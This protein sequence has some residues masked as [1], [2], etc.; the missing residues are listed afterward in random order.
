M[1]F[2]LR[3]LALLACGVLSAQAE[4]ALDF[5]RDIRPLL[6][7]RCFAC[8]GFDGRARKGD[9][10]LD[11]PEGAYAP[12][13]HGVTIVPGKPDQSLLWQRITTTDREDVMP[14]ADSHLKLADAEK[15]LLRRWIES[16]AGYEPPWALQ[17]VV[18]PEPP[19]A[20]VHP[21]DAFVGDRLTKEKLAFAPEAPK[22]VLIRR[23]SFDLRARP[24][25]PEEVRDLLTDSAPEAYEKLVD[26]FLADPA[27]GERMAWPWLDAARYADRMVSRAM[28]TGR[29]G[30]GGTGCCSAFNRNLPYDQ[31]TIWQ[32]AGDLLP[33][34]TDEVWR[35]ASCAIIRSTARAAVSR[36]STASIHDGHGGDDGDGVDGADDE[37]RRCHDHKYDPLTQRDYYSLYAFFNQ[38]PVDGSGGN[39]QTPPV[40]AVATEEQRGREE[41]LVRGIDEMRQRVVARMAEIVPAGSDWE[42][43]RLAQDEWHILNAGGITGTEAK[44]LNDGS[45]LTFGDNPVNATYGVR[46]PVPAG[47]LTAVRLD[48]LRDRSMTSGGIARSDSGNFVLTGFEAVL[49]L[50]DGS[51]RKLDFAHAKATYEQGGLSVEGAIDANPNTGW[52]V[53]EGRPVDRDHC[54]VFYLRAA[55][56]VPAGTFV[57]FTLRHES[58][59][60]HHNLGRF[61]L[62]VSGTEVPHLPAAEAMVLTGIL[63]IP[64]DLRTPEQRQVV[65]EARGGGDAELKRLKT[66]QTKQETELAALRRGGPKV[67]VMADR[68]EFRQTHVLSV[69]G[70][71]K[72]LAEVTAATPGMLPPLVKTGERANRLDL[73]RWLVSRDHPLT[74]RV[75]VNRI[76]QEFFGVGLVKTA[77]GLRGAGREADASGG[78]RLA[79]GGFYRPAAGT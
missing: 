67:M 26:R 41:K 30:R 4:T 18:K 79:G 32:L 37:L 12:R 51:R 35:P 13:E 17:R 72:P 62:A 48:A 34:A 5:N 74:A 33:G 59:N 3:N 44:V 61:R 65:L 53:Y 16:G 21:V 71:D 69:G 46:A 49:A 45:V 38:S 11:T 10:R 24:P 19:V 77:G 29:C 58:R 23:L 78:A 54:A 31:F 76:W 36:K 55:V 25:S 52:A 20:G 70:Y 56:E 28:R 6:S 57:E 66:E 1:I 47:P 40:I 73:A 2:C 50:P 43:E 39:P 8:H 27:Y 60:A 68:K 75:T 64:A 63:R 15:A 22:A 9:L 14:P 7:D 42:A